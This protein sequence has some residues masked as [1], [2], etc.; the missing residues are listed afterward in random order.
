MNLVGLALAN[1][2]RLGKFGQLAITALA[3]LGGFKGAPLVLVSRYGDTDRMVRLLKQ[4]AEEE[5]LSPT[6]FSLSVHNAV[7]GIVAI[8]WQNFEAMTAIAGG[9]Q[10][11][12]SGFA[13]VY[14]RLHEGAEVVILLVL[15]HDLPPPYEKFIEDPGNHDLALAMV[16]CREPERSQ[17]ANSGGLC[18]IHEPHNAEGSAP[19]VLRQLALFLENP[20]TKCW[21]NAAHSFP[22]R[23][24]N[25]QA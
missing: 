20:T 2:R 4:L 12:Q 23:L 22:W 10:S 14:A 25:G 13:E 9:D 5:P 24:V 16:F 17:E 1:R 19:V 15:D 21:P 18:L 8:A 3:G 6:D 11:L 7:N